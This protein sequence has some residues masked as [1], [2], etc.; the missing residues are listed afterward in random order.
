MADE[1]TSGGSSNP[2][3]DAPGD[4][5]VTIGALIVAAAWLIF[6]VITDDYGTGSLIP[7]L[8]LIILVM[9]RLD[10]DAITAVAPMEAFVKAAGYGLAVA[11]VVEFVADIDANIFDAGGATLFGAIVTYVGYVAAFLGAQRTQV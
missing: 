7:V 1:S 8:A 10:K 5:L 6:D 3:A 2:L 4:T 11:G 9:P